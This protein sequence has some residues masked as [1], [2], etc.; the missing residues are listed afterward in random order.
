MASNYLEVFLIS[1]FRRVQYVVCFLL[2]N[3]PVSEL[4]VPLGKLEV[5]FF[6]RGFD[7]H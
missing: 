6:N 5:D 4:E 3:S 2:G 7:R 1:N